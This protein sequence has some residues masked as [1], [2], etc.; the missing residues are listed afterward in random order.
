[1]E[2]RRVMLAAGAVA[3]LA[4][5]GDDG[6]GGQGPGDEPGENEVLVRNNSFTPATIQVE[7]GTTI[8]WIWS[9]NGVEHNVTFDDGEDSGTQGSGTYTRN[10]ADV[11]DFPYHCTIHGTATS[12]MRGTVTVI[13]TGGDTG[14]GGGGGGG[15][16]GGGYPDDGPGGY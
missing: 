16:N 2:L 5:G 4:C 11:G 12:G 9:S 15:G 10:F 8:A 1:M 13:V 6:N 14:N 3:A 7:A